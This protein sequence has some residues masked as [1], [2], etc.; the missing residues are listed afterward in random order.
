M[1]KIPDEIIRCVCELSDRGWPAWVEFPQGKKYL[2]TDIGTATVAQLEQAVELETRRAKKQILSYMESPTKARAKRAAQ[3][4]DR[5]NAFKHRS[6][7]K[8]GAEYSEAAMPFPFMSEDEM[9]SHLKQELE[10]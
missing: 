1:T 7:W 10:S 3:T 4:I 2:W 9:R 6:L 5:A 8:Q